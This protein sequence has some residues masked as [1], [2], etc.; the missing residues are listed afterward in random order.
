MNKNFVGNLFCRI[1]SLHKKI[2]LYSLN[3]IY[4]F[5]ENLTRRNPIHLKP[6]IK[7]KNLCTDFSIKKTF[8]LT[9]YEEPIY[10][11]F[12][13][14]SSLEFDSSI[15]EMRD[16]RKFSQNYPIY[17][18]RKSPHLPQLKYTER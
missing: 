18:S 2:S 4:I 9:F 15:W 14:L 1:V 7:T 17:K 8:F 11:L 6:D 12:A 10:E 13:F 3:K 16:P 5:I